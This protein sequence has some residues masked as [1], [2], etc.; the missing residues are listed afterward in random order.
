MKTTVF[1]ILV[2]CSFAC[3]RNNPQAKQET[4]TCEVRE[5]P[6]DYKTS[7]Y[8]VDIRAGKSAL[9]FEREQLTSYEYDLINLNNSIPV[10]IKGEGKYVGFGKSF[11]G[12]EMHGPFAE[13][14]VI[15]DS[16][17]KVVH[18]KGEIKG[19]IMQGKVF[20]FDYPKVEPR[21]GKFGVFEL[22]D[23]SGKRGIYSEFFPIN[24]SLFILPMD[25]YKAI[26]TADGYTSDS[27]G[28][29]K[30]IYIVVDY[31]KEEAVGQAHSSSRSIKETKLIDIFG[32]ETKIIRTTKAR[33]A[34]VS[35]DKGYGLIDVK[36]TIVVPALFFEYEV[37]GDSVIRF[38][39]PEE[40]LKLNL[41]G[42]PLS[43]GNK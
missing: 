33:T 37:V 17:I 23:D 19:Y 4:S 36:G 5:N 10:L 20:L 43:S 34:V 38:I 42:K 35:S 18:G 29:W 28:T 1:L 24:G 9:Y 7:K 12:F 15:N 14:E 11:H 27:G 32:C 40:T 6:S 41:W 31:F 25:Y 2:I 8:S 16:V 3:N 13:V 22:T 26:Y 21:T 39:N 30:S